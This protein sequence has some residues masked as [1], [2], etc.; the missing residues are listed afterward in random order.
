VLSALFALAVRGDIEQL[1]D[2]LRLAEEA[3]LPAPVVDVYG[4]WRAL[5]AGEEGPRSLPAEAAG[6]IVTALGALLRVQELEAFETLHAL[7]LRVAIEPR[8]RRE[9]LAQLYLRRGFLESA[10][11]EWIAVCDERPD[12]RALVGLA[13]VAYARGFGGDVEALAEAAL[14]LDP[15]SV[16]AARLLAAARRIPTDAAPP[17]R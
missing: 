15:D 1:G 8:E 16:E 9:L 10:A 7:L 6:P 5:L 14:E 3:G 11:D 12:V 4:A 13:Q 2:Q 17:L